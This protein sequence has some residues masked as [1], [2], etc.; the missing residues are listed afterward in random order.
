MAGSQVPGLLLRHDQGVGRRPKAPEDQREAWPLETAQRVR[1]AINARSASPSCSR[2]AAGCRRARSSGCRRKTSTSPVESCASADRSNSSAGGCTS[3]CRRAAARSGARPGDEEVPAR[4]HHDVRQRPSREH[5]QRRGV[6][7]GPGSRRRHPHA[8]EGRTAEGVAQGRLPRAS[9]HVR[10]GHPGSG[11]IPEVGGRGRGAIDA[12]LSQ[13]AL[14]R[15]VVR[16]STPAIAGDRAHRS[17]A[18]S[19]RI[20]PSGLGSAVGARVPGRSHSREN[21]RG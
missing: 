5:P 19:P 6:E 17:A 21:L 9:A 10:P 13:P 16:G 15:R 3:P 8:T 2:L 14:Q 20:L 1:E 12:L 4:H 18:H 7:A 11:R